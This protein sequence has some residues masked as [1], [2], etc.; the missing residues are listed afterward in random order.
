MVS[1]SSLPL[2][3]YAL[4][5]RSCSSNSRQVKLKPHL[6]ALAERES[7]LHSHSTICLRSLMN[8]LVHPVNK[9]MTHFSLVCCL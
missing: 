9:T 1:M 2:E 8:V 3:E 4:T 7:R 6:D 5:I